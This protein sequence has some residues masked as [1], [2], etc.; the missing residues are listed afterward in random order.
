MA[1]PR[2]FPPLSAWVALALMLGFA[3]LTYAMTPRTYL[4][5]TLPKVQLESMLPRS[6]NGWHEDPA[7]MQVI[8]NPQIEAA[9]ASIYTDTLARTYL[10]SSGKRMM[11]SVAYGRDQSGGSALHYPEVCY[12]A[13][14]LPILSSR[15]E[16]TT[17]DGQNVEVRRLVAGRNAGVREYITYWVI[18]GD[19]AVL[20]RTGHSL[21]LMHYGLRGYIPDGMLVRVSSFGEDDGEYEQQRVFMEQLLRTI[22]QPMRSRVEGAHG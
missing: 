4:A 1:D 13:Q 11:L 8:V 3:A 14:G 22:P 10:N 12:P 16:E 6:F 21:T 7:V 2:R 17:I 9:V 19:R 20:G 18:V 15:K 5:D